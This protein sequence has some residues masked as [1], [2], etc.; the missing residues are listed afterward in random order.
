MF[1]RDIIVDIHINFVDIDINF[2]WYWGLISILLILG[3]D[4]NSVDIDFIVGYIIV[5]IL[6]EII[7][8]VYDIIVDVIIIAIIADI[9]YVDVSVDI[10][11][12]YS[13]SINM[14]KCCW[15]F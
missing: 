11:V 8:V 12:E 3:T 10:D 4:I 6:V 2:C 15:E 7:E 1:L 14:Q 13:Y 9:N 5:D